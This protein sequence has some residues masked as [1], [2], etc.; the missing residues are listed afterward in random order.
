MS[1]YE[2]GILETYI[3]ATIGY[4]ALGARLGKS[5]KSLMRMLGPS[6][7]PRADN[8]LEIVRTLNAH[9]KVRPEVKLKAR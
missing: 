1:D 2:R 6:G 3:D 8:L 7:N 9:E 4:P 5:P